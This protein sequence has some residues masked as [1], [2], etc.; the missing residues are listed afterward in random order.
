MKSEMARIKTAE[1]AERA[2]ELLTFSSTGLKE[3]EPA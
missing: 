1:L 3:Q 2:R